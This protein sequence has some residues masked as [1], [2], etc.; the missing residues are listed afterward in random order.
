MAT[1]K[2]QT[3]FS[4]GNTLQGSKSTRSKKN[5]TQFQ[6]PKKKPLLSKEAEEERKRI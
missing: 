6:T 4:M 5:S 1:T 3:G 2:H